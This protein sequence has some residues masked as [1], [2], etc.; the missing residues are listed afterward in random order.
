[1]QS[2]SRN[3]SLTHVSFV[4]VLLAAL[5]FVA[6]LMVVRFLL[7]SLLVVLRKKGACSLQPGRSSAAPARP[8]AALIVSPCIVKRVCKA[9][10][11]ILGMDFVC[12]CTTRGGVWGTVTES[13]K[14]PVSGGH[15]TE[16]NARCHL[17]EDKL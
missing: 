10:R 9:L 14:T 2:Q 5:R 15:L 13:V 7:L 12:K 4:A 11:F 17:V 8:A 3:L 6:Q 1:M 16:A